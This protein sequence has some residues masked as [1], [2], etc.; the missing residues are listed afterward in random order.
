MVLILKENIS[1]FHDKF[2]AKIFVKNLG[3][4]SKCGIKVGHQRC[5][6]LGSSQPLVQ[7]RAHV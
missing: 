4:I 2:M 6:V 3:F 1:P 7:E 5:D